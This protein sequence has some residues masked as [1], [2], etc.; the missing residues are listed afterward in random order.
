MINY[1]TLTPNI[2]GARR[3]QTGLPSSSRFLA[4]NHKAKKVNGEIETASKHLIASIWRGGG[5]AKFGRPQRG[6]IG[7]DSTNL[8]KGREGVKIPKILRT[9]FMDGPLLKPT[10]FDRPI[11]YSGRVFTLK[12]MH[13]TSRKN[14]VFEWW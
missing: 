1:V 14:E 3:A 9:Y 10:L 8:N 7:H 6:G 4:Q 12:R 5:Q 11:P 13:H 2:S